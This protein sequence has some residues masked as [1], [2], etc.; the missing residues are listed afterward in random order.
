MGSTRSPRCR[1]TGD[2]DGSGELGMG[3]SL[4]LGLIN[5]ARRFAKRS[6]KPDGVVF[7]YC[8]TKFE[9][10]VSSNPDLKEEG[11]FPGYGW[12]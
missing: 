10:A 6:D 9:P 3:S 11:V 4:E 7:W 2:S 1:G 8:W 12:Y 5:S